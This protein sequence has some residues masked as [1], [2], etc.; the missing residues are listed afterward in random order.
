MANLEVM[1][2]LLMAVLGAMGCK[3][4]TKDVPIFPFSGSIVEW[5]THPGAFTS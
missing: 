1:S 2:E 3:L 5:K 4:N